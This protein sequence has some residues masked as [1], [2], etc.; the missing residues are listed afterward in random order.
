MTSKEIEELVEF[1][2]HIQWRWSPGDPT[3]SMD[4][5]AE[6]VTYLIRLPSA[7]ASAVKLFDLAGQMRAD[8]LLQHA[9]G[10]PTKRPAAGLGHRIGTGRKVLKVRDKVSI[11]RT[12]VAGDPIVDTETSPEDGEALR[13]QHEDITPGYHINAQHWIASCP[14]AKLQSG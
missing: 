13:Q 7:S 1:E 9:Q 4:A 12:E 5:L 10:R 3:D 14:A 6:Y 8:A 2:K 11:L